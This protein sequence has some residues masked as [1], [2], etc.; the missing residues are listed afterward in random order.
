MISVP[1]M[2][3]SFQ[4]SGRH[5][6]TSVFGRGN[7]HA[8]RTW[9]PC[10]VTSAAFYPIIVC[11]PGI[12]CSAPSGSRAEMWVSLRSRRA[13]TQPTVLICVLAFAFPSGVFPAFSNSC[14]VFSA[15]LFC[16]TVVPP[17]ATSCEQDDSRVL[18]GR[19]RHGRFPLRPSHPAETNCPFDD[20][21][22]YASSRRR[23]IGRQPAS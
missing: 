1:L 11:S 16:Q 14:E 21:S 12:E 6:I 2:Q 17:A 19:C 4:Q 8:K 15:W 18:V 5:D 9:R 20:R 22:A 3:R 23:S 7:Q 13:N 10:H